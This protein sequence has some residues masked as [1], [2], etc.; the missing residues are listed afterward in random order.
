[1]VP[2]AATMKSDEFVKLKSMPPTLNMSTI[3][4]I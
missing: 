4:L 3:G 2:A 1:M